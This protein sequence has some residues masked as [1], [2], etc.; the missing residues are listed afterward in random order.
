MCSVATVCHN[1]VNTVLDGFD[2]TLYINSVMSVDITTPLDFR[3]RVLS[4]LAGGSVSRFLF[5][6][7]GVSFHLVHFFPFS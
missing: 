3:V 2:M 5:K 4:G 1:S 7:G 6:V